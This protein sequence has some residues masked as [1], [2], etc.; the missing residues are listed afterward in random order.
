LQVSPSESVGNDVVDLQA[1]GS[2]HHLRWA[3]RAFT[4]RERADI[5]EDLWRESLAWAAKE[6]AYKCYRRLE[7]KARFIP[8]EYDVFLGTQAVRHAGVEFIFER[9]A[10]EA[11]GECLAIVAATSH[12]VL[13]R[14]FHVVRR[15]REAKANPS[16]VVRVEAALVIAERFRIPVC[17][18]SFSPPDPWRAPVV[19]LQGE[20]A[21]AMVS[22]SHDGRFVAFSITESRSASGSAVHLG[23]RGIRVL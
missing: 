8:R 23:A 9:S 13:M 1:T 10:H 17:E 4:D 22:F 5:G 19:Y 18:V 14:T 6:A 2:L 12:E 3:E 15:L 7:P 20:T 16:Q 11:C 21:P